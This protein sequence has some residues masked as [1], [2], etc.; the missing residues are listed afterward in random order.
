MNTMIDVLNALKTKNLQG[1]FLIPQLG[2]APLQYTV[3]DVKPELA[4]L[5]TVITGQTYRIVSHPN[6]LIFIERV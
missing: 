1:S 5:E 3:V 4:T 6:T 2:T